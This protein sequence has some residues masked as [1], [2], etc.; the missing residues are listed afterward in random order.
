M[1]RS[2]IGSP[3]TVLFVQTMPTVD[4][5]EQ[6]GHHR[7]VQVEEGN[8]AERERG[9]LISKFVPRM[10][11]RGAPWWRVVGQDTSVAGHPFGIYSAIR[12]RLPDRNNDYLDADQ[13]Q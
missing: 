11:H 8:D 2:P 1:P 5:A 13:I 9:L 6:D 12:V 4:A 3:A 10:L 7:M